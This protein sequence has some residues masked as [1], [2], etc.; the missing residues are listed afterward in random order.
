[1]SE[2]RR[3]RYGKGEDVGGCGGRMVFR[4]AGGGWMVPGG[5]KQLR[6]VRGALTHRSGCYGIEAGYYSLTTSKG[7]STLTSLWSLM[8]AV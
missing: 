1:M 4:R 5:D 3:K 2:G 8:V 6:C 7:I